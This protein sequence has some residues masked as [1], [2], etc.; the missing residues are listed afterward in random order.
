MLADSCTAFLSGLRRNVE[1][2]NASRQCQNLCNMHI[3]MFKVLLFSASKLI[4][5]VSCQANE[6]NAFNAV[7]C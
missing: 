1:V 7:G 6:F 2:E 5:L 3:Y 4:I